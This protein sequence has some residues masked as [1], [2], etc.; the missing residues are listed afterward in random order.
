[1]SYTNL[2][3]LRYSP[4]LLINKEFTKKLEEEV[5]TSPRDSY[6]YAKRYLKKRWKKG[7]DIILTCPFSSVGY[8]TTV[9]KKRWPKAEP[10]IA[11]NAGTAV[12]YTKALLK[13]PWPL[14]EPVIL[15]S[16][17][18][19]VAYVR[20]VLKSP[21]YDLELRFLQELDKIVIGNSKDLA[22]LERH[23]RKYIEYSSG[24]N[25]KVDNFYEN[26][27][28]ASTLLHF[29]K[30]KPPLIMFLMRFLKLKTYPLAEP[31]ILTVKN[32]REVYLFSYKKTAWP[33]IEPFLAEDSGLSYK[34]AVV[35]LIGR[36]PLGEPVITLD[37]FTNRSYLKFL[38]TLQK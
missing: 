10:V 16:L 13:K 8:A 9:L 37:H 3:K 6:I 33:E 36:F 34:Y 14:A 32:I 20:K 24:E 27:T 1:M 38:K 35:C 28:F 4:H 31:T 23:I 5:L 29:C 17:D 11:S 19:S 12:G 26:S 7:E 2:Q 30:D 18:R 22:L 25:L 15:R 21:W